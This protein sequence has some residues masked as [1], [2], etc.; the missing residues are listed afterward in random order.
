MHFALY[1][2]ILAAGTCVLSAVLT[3]LCIRISARFGLA[4]QPR[5]DRWHASATPNTGGIA[6][7]VS[8]A[9]VYV[10]FGPSRY[11][12]IAAAASGIAILGF[13]DD[14]VRL[15]PLAK[16]CGQSLAVLVVMATGVVFHVTSSPPLNFALT[17][18]W[19][20]GVTNAFNLIDNMDGLCAG[21]TIII[22]GF[23]FWPALHSGDAAG[24][25]SLAILA[26]GFLGFLLFNYKPAKIFM[27][28]AGSMF[29]GFTLASL[30]I[31]APV[32]QTRVFLSAI[33]Y[34]VLTFLYPIF[35]TVLVSVLRRMAGTRISAGGRDHSSHRLASLGLKE[36]RVVWLLWVLTAMGAAGGLLTYSMPIGILAIAF[37]LTLATTIFGVFLASLPGY[38]LPQ[39]TLVSASWLRGYIPTLRAGLTLLVD[40]LI[41]GA[42]LLISFLLKWERAFSG[43]PVADLL[44]ALPVVMGCQVAACLALGT[45]N[46]GWR[47]IGVQDVFALGRCALLS[48]LASLA[49]GWGVALQGYSRGV[50]CSYALLTFLAMTGSRILLWL[51]WR[52]LASPQNGRRAAIL[53][54]GQ[55]AELIIFMLRRQK[56]LNASPVLILDVDPTHNG[57]R[58]HGI[59]VCCTASNPL[60]VLREASINL[61]I[62]PTI[63]HRLTSAQRLVV[64]ACEI[65]AIPVV[66]FECRLSPLTSPEPKRLKNT[67]VRA[68]RSPPAA[69]FA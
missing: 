14:R 52:L 53:G 29:A 4:A 11:S 18:L 45:F 50:I 69:G 68:S 25:A 22:C 17:F 16:F 44:S 49:V 13:I 12:G 43:K 27:G 67:A 63:H 33:L 39:A 28:D 40:T 10:A 54:A 23:R 62:L 35:D 47:W 64:D 66:Q 41:A 60:A 59:P 7:F 20:A 61:L 48:S 37:F 65:L 9:I 8:C 51:L 32:P 55:S 58:I 26:G 21:V 38:E 15:G 30:A 1:M 42:S 24:A 34:P 36:Q 56:E 31:A 3:W 19:I 5:L 6:V 2:G 46:I 57:I